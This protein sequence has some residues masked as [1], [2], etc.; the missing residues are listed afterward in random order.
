MHIG[1]IGFVTG[2]LLALLSAGSRLSGAEAAGLHYGAVMMFSVILMA[3]G[4]IA[5]EYT[6]WGE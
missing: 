4:L 2:F 1:V 5:M 6:K 3:G